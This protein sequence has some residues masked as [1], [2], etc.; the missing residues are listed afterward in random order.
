MIENLTAEQLVSIFSGDGLLTTVINLTFFITG[1]FANVYRCMKENNIG[2]IDYWKKHGKRSFASGG[3]L[4]LSFL[5]LAIMTPD[6]P[7][8]AYFSMAIMS[9][10]I[11]NKSPKAEEIKD[12]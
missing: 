11:M 10:A 9:D 5:G 8:Y 7:I 6:A 4:L 2:F 3:T 1:I 12:A